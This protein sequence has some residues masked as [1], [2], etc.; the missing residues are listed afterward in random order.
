LS[1]ESSAVCAFPP[2]V[3]SAIVRLKIE[4][5][6][7]RP[8]HLRYLWQRRACRRAGGRGLRGSFCCVSAPVQQ[9]WRTR[10]RSLCAAACPA[11]TPRDRRA[12]HAATRPKTGQAAAG[13]PSKGKMSTVC[14]NTSRTLQQ[15]AHHALK[16]KDKIENIGML[17][18]TSFL[19]K[20]SSSAMRAV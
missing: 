13:R 12:V 18:S 8:P 2:A 5:S 19:R 9:Q 15:E 16:V 1:S 20:E 7:T 11:R 4:R 17:T 14:E 6:S 10:R 3:S